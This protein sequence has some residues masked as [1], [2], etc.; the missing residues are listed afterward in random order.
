[1][2]TISGKWW[3]AS[4]LA[5]IIIIFSAWKPGGD[6]RKVQ[7]RYEDED[8]TRPRKK[9]N[10]RNEI[11][12]SELNEAMKD[13]EKAMDEMSRDIKFDFSKMDKEI[14]LA[15]DEVKK[16]DFD[17]I[18]KEIDIAV[19]GISWD[20]TRQEVDKALRE[21]E[22]NLKGIDTK[23]LKEDLAAAKIE[24]ELKKDIMD[25]DL[26]KTIRSSI[27]SG[28]AAAR[29]GIEAA[30]KELIL[31]KEFIDTLDK[32]GLIDKKKGFKLQIRDGE[33][34]INDAKQPKEVN[35]K[36]KKYIEDR[37]DFTITS[38]EEGTARI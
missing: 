29:T 30:K 8:T 19:K 25:I 9:Y 6:F 16:I 26:G 4:G 23:A 3:V 17:K 5:L 33:L 34:Y 38:D 11:R 27:E 7:V 14:K 21:V 10:Y 37:Q 13:L 24:L 2:K 20:K 28:M 12:M 1:M 15:L 32:D 18:G 22:L 35:N 36:Y 31:L